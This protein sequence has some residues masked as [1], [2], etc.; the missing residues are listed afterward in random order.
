M[1]IM[2]VRRTL[3]KT[4]I[5]RCGRMRSIFFHPQAWEVSNTI[6]IAMSMAL[7]HSTAAGFREPRHTNSSKVHKA[8]ESDGPEV[9]GEEYITTVKLEG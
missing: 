9:L 3:S 5:E 6:L 4:E 2:R 7:A 1:T 8:G